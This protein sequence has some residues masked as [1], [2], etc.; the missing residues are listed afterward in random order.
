MGHAKA[1]D[2]RELGMITYDEIISKTLRQLTPLPE[3]KERGEKFL[4][5]LR[6]M[7]SLQNADWGKACGEKIAIP[8]IIEI[9]RID[10]ANHE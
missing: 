9:E 2:A 7:N 4:N 3:Q 6:H 1:W 8:P 5:W 10:D